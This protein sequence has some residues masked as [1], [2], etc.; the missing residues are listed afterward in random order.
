MGQRIVL[1][2]FGSFGDIYPYLGLARRLLQCGHEPVVATSASYRPLVE[3]EGVAFRPVRPDI[4]LENRAMIRRV[5]EP[6]RGPGVLIREVL[7]PHL[8][9]SYADL[10]AAT[11]GADLLVTHP[12]TFAGPLVAERQ[13]VPWASTVL[14]PFSFFSAYD[15]PVFP[16][17]P[18]LT[19]LQRL[20]PR[21]NRR[22]LQAVRWVARRWP[23]PVHRLRA[24]LGLPAAADPLYAGQFSPGLTLAL[25]SRLLAMPQ[26][27]WPPH[28]RVVGF[29]DYQGPH[30]LPPA[31]AEFL[32][33]GPAPL[34]FTLGTSAVSAA[35][36]F[37]RESLEAVRRLG[38]RAVL[39]I[40]TDPEN[41]P[42]E[43]LPAGVLA[44]PYAPHGDLF[45]R[46]RAVIH[47]GGVGTTAQA[48]RAGRP[49]LV[50]PYAF[51]Q[52]DNAR[53]VGQLGVA[54]TLAPKR[55]TARRVV[56]QLRALGE[57]SHYARRAAEVGGLVRA[58]DG[59][60]RA[61]E[62]LEAFLARAPHGSAPG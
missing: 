4:D 13:G 36:P 60:E 11:R 50:V 61:C 38:E 58:E 6:T 53:R 25:F 16:P 8:R 9:D 22:L 47:Q 59:V 39:L 57:D 17:L 26:P 42:P 28:T 54:R 5:M 40:G 37:Y 2:S 43:P 31:V 46:A 10:A 15:P 34:V 32:E 49:M 30:R 35:G 24:D 41:R 48:L 27:D 3:G 19:G 7:L 29:I 62:A 33:A 12:I 1:T 14:A 56:A 45:P 55:Y 20:G 44:V 18:W 51:D 21:V 52:P 23:E